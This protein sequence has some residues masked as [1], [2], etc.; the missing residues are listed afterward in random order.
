[1]SQAK[2]TMVAGQAISLAELFKYMVGKT[3]LDGPPTYAP[4]MSAPDGPSTAGGKQSLQH[5]TLVPEG[6]GGTLVIGAASLVEK[7]CELRS[8]AHVSEIFQQRF[9]GATFA[10]A[11]DKYDALL[12]QIRSFFSERGFRVTMADMPVSRTVPPV[13]R[14]TAG[15]ATAASAAA[16]GGFGLGMVVG[17]AALAAVLVGLVVF[18]L[19]R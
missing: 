16:P 11:A 8:W 6:T 4:E 1:M 10:V 19:K 13:G 15:T 7:T 5:I 14:M 3:R 9:K 12:E 17:I 2:H 18:F